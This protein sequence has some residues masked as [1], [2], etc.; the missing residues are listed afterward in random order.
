MRNTQKD[1]MFQ[2]LISG[3]DNRWGNFDG[4]AEFSDFVIRIGGGKKEYKIVL[5]LYNDL[6]RLCRL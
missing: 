1:W 6:Q 5:S 3:M 2:S 4:R